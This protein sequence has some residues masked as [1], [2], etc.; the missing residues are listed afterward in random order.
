MKQILGGIRKA[1]KDFE[2]IKDGDKI[3]VGVSGGKDSMILLYGLKLFQRFSPQKYD[4][5]AITVDAGFKD[6][7]FS[8]IQK[9]CDKIEVPYRLI[10]TQISEIVFHARQEKNP[11]S[12]CS[13]M[14]KGALHDE[15]NRLGYNVSAL[16][17]HG[18]DVV[19]TMFMS[20]FF[21]GRIKTFK[22]A[23][24]LSRKEIYSIRPMIYLKEK[25]I[26]SAL[27]R[28][29]IPCVSSGCPADKKT[30]REEI[31]K[32][33]ENIYKEIPEGRDRVLKSIGNTK[34]LDLWS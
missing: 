8:E 14:K 17:H 31:K 23:T 4:L 24:Y 7:D 25:Q 10:K 28:N 18:D 16:G 13:K 21:E 33:L 20:M 30:K 32:I 1:V 27:K 6:A 9:F 15:M 22:P 2:M 26:I 12:L 5:A 11:C 29:G 34:E 19:E 3:A